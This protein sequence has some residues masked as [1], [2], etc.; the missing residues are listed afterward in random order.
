MGKLCFLQGQS[1]WHTHR[2]ISSCGGG[3]GGWGGG[4][5]GAV[6]DFKLSTLPAIVWMVNSCGMQ[7]SPRLHPLPNGQAGGGGGGAGGDAGGGDGSWDGGGGGAE[8]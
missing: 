8:V 6:V 2:R 4:G 1:T 7:N 5:G 3:G